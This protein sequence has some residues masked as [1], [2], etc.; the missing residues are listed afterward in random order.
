MRRPARKQASHRAPAR[1]EIVDTHTLHRLILI[2]YRALSSSAQCRAAA[3]AR[4]WGARQSWEAAIVSHLVTHDRVRC[5][6]AP[7]TLSH[8]Y[9][10]CAR[11]SSWHALA[12]LRR[13]RGTACAGGT[14]L[15]TPRLPPTRICGRRLCRLQA[16]SSRSGRKRANMLSRASHGGGG[17]EVWVYLQQVYRHGGE[18]SSLKL[19]GG[20][21]GAS[22]EAGEEVK[23]K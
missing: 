23:E 20:D 17:L 5:S 2:P 3:R 7:R 12:L 6:A 21:G 1:M 15:M 13:A 9:L 4:L 10:I 8:A 11:H 18:R 16:L 22:G 14:R 19:R